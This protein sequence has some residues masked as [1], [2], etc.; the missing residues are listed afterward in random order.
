MKIK[1]EFAGGM[2]LLFEGKK[3]IELD[4]Q[5]VKEGQTPLTL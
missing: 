1:V 5:D 4:L 2:E 3:T